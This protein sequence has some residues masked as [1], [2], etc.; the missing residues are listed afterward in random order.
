MALTPKLAAS[1]RAW[2]PPKMS[3]PG[4][5]LGRVRSMRRAPTYF[6]IVLSFAVLVAQSGAIAAGSVK[7]SAPP[8]HRSP[9]ERTPL[10]AEAPS[11]PG[12]DWSRRRAEAGLQA[13]IAHKLCVVGVDGCANGSGL[14]LGAS[15]AS[16]PSPNFAWGARLARAAFEE[17]L[18]FENERLDLEQAALSANLFGRVHPFA[19]GSFDPYVEL[20]AGGGRF[21]EVGTWSSDDG[22]RL[23][24]D[25]KTWA[26]LLEAAFAVDWHWASNVKVG[27]R[28]G[29][30]HWLLAP[31]ERCQGVVFGACTVPARGHFDVANA[32]LAWQFGV[33]V[34]FGNPH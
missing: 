33:A 3:Q 8:S 6:A 2:Q 16:R 14:A 27:A 5:S 18:R 4:P 28:F 31:W 1:T 21:D 26:P 15:F 7:S 11:L 32:V 17:R 12:A 30:T 10:I 13:G 23:S 25:E 20:A 22:L 29:W 19:L 9:P 34:L 24:L